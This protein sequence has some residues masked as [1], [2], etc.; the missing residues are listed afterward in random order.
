MIRPLKV[1][2]LFNG[3]LSD[4]LFP[5]L[6]M[7]E[8]LLIHGIDVL[9]MFMLTNSSVKVVLEMNHLTFLILLYHISYLLNL[10]LKMLKN[11]YKK[12]LD[13]HSMKEKLKNILKLKDLKPLVNILM[14][15][16]QVKSL[17]LIIWLNLL[18]VYNLKEVVVLLVMEMLNY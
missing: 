8:E 2:P 18:Q 14:L 5:K 12:V 15:K 13:P 9:W 4:I 16:F 3:M 11:N 6:P 17:I 1:F 10:L 7:V